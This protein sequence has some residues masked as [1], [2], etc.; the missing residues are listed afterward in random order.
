MYTLKPMKISGYDTHL[1]E[2]ERKETLP[3]LTYLGST[4]I[5]DKKKHSAM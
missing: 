5:R 4:F 3:N 1:P 2:L